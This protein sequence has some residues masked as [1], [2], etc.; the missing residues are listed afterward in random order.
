MCYKATILTIAL[1]LI[2]CTVNSTEGNFLV[3][4]M[5]VFYESIVGKPSIVSVVVFDCPACLTKYFL[6]CS[7]CHES[8]F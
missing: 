1:V 7:F 2:I 8:L 6:P 5:D 3:L 4:A